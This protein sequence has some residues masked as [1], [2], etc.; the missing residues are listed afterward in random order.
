MAKWCQVPAVLL[1]LLLLAGCKREI[2]CKCELIDDSGKF[3]AITSGRRTED[4]L[5]REALRAA[6]DKRCAGMSGAAQACVARCT[7]DA[8]VGKIGMRSTCSEGGR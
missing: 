7:V 6:C 8:V 5:R 3:E 4:E 1:L 2:H